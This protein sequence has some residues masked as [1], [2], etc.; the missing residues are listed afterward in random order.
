MIYENED[1]RLVSIDGPEFHLGPVVASG[2]EPDRDVLGP[3]PV[4]EEDSPHQDPLGIG[5]RLRGEEVAAVKFLQTLRLWLL[6]LHVTASGGHRG[7]VTGR[8]PS[9]RFLYI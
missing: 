3:V 4:D 2:M 6:L 8:R 1:S 5:E 9:V 7:G